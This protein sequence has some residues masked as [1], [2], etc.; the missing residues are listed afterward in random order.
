[1]EAAR[2][3]KSWTIP[4]GE[5]SKTASLFNQFWTWSEDEMVSVGENGLAP[6]FAHLSVSDCLDARASGGADKSRR[7]N[8]AVRSVNYTGAH[9]TFLFDNIEF[10]HC[11]YYNR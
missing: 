1:M 2:V 11:L 10:Q 4:A 6:K 9:E 3:G 7:L 5:F 8:I